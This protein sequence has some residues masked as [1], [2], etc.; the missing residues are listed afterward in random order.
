[1]HFCQGAQSFQLCQLLND[2]TRCLENDAYNVSA[3]QTNP[4]QLNLRFLVFYLL[5]WIQTLAKLQHLVNC[6]T[7]TARKA[8]WPQFVVRVSGWAWKCVRQS[9][10]WADVIWHVCM[11]IRSAV[12]SC[13]VKRRVCFYS[14]AL[15][16]KHS[17]RIQES[18]RKEKGWRKS[19]Q[20]EPQ[21]AE[22]LHW[23][24]F[25]WYSKR[26]LHPALGTINWLY[27]PIRGG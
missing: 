23:F 6:L 14:I 9:W 5:L 13:P 2:V 17:T 11:C 24:I 20:T 22:R 3:E 4:V 1:M 18:Y 27:Q 25:H 7:L 10:H 12:W 16:L 19:M 15:Q 8:T 26:F 21:W